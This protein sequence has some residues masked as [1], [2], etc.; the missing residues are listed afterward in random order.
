MH[1]T[2]A[3]HV[4]DSLHDLLEEILGIPF[5]KFPALADVVKQ[6]ATRTQF[7]HH[8][9]VFVCLKGL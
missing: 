6:V 3:V 4:G 1:D 9:V 2:N 8:Q 7:H 5:S